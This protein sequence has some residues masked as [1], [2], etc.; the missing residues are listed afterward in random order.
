M[1]KYENFLRMVEAD[2]IYRCLN[3]AR[4]DLRPSS[5]L[6]VAIQCPQHVLSEQPDELRIQAVELVDWFFGGPDPTWLPEHLFYEEVEEE[7]EEI[8]EVEVGGYGLP[9]TEQELRR[10]DSYDGI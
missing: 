6:V 4:R 2:A 5:V 8:I 7:I 1:T 3:E 10:Q 9:E